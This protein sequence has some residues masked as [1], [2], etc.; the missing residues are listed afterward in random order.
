MDRIPEFI[1]NHPLMI[2]ALVATI[3]MIVFM[4]YQRATQAAKNLSPSAAT[5]L[6]NSEDAVFIDV[7][8]RKSY[9]AGHL[10][11]AQSVPLN[12]LEQH[13][14]QLEKLKGVPW[15]L[16]DE[17]GMQA[18]RA[19]KTLAKKGFGPLYA[20]DGGLPAWTKAEL[21]LSTGKKRKKKG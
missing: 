18:Q 9:E 8:P 1:S 14:K 15:I 6:R 17:G 13:L 11:G 3:G 4:E 12:E 5:R 19:A 20:L 21:P 10:P 16:Y 2:A 7:R